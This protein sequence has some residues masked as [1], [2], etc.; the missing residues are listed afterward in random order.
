M[1]AGDKGNEAALYIQNVFA[2]W[3]RAKNNILQQAG[4]TLKNIFCIGRD[5]E[6][7]LVFKAIKHCDLQLTSDMEILQSCDRMA[8]GQDTVTK[9]LGRIGNRPVE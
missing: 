3:Q 7:P 1:K 8:A 5:A 4:C 6:E 9:K 2:G